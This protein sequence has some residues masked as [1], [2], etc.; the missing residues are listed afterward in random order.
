MDIFVEKLKKWVVLDK[1]MKFVNEKTR[2]IRETKTALTKELTDFVHRGNVNHKVIEITNGE[3]RF[4]EK[5]DY[6]PLTFSYIKEC[7]DEMISDKMQVDAI[8][9][10]LK[11]K[12][13]VRTSYEIRRIEFEDIPSSISK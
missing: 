10:Y 13:E 1:Q 7:L 3:L 8:I 6:S 4:V 5:R 2:Q 9:Q 11:D 12:R